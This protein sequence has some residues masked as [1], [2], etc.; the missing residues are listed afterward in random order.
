[1]TRSAFQLELI[2]GPQD[3]LRRSSQSV[4]D[5]R[6]LFPLRPILIRHMAIPY[7]RIEDTAAAV[8]RFDHAEPAKSSPDGDPILCYRFNGFTLPS[9]R[10]TSTPHVKKR[11]S[12]SALLIFAECTGR[13]LCEWM[14]S[15]VPYPMQIA[16]S[17]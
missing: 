14:M 13:R 12:P 10:T 2:G 11:H 17:R 6:L 9:T 3:G 7:C 16:R 15:P 4:P 8:Y 1:M 5:S